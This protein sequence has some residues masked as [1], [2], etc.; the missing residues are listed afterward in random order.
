MV[1]LIVAIASNNVIGKNND[2][3]WHLP[4]DMRFFT[5]TTKG[6]V[7][8]MGRRN[9]NSIPDKYRP[10]PG[11]LNIVVSRDTSFQDEGC[12]V[13]D[14]IESA[15][16]AHSMDECDTYIIGGGQVYAYCLEKDLVDEMLISKVDQDFDGDTF[17]PDIDLDNWNKESI[18]KYQKDD[19]NPHSFEVWRYTKKNGLE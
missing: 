2:L 18:L 8:I 10:L 14:S 13:Y 17:F 12:E 16:A 3:I 19:Q 11:R 6:N 5:Q 1:K 7:V 9:W 4:A 15:I